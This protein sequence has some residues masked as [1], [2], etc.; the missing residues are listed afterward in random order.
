MALGA[1]GHSSIRRSRGWGAAPVRR[2]SWSSRPGT[3]ESRLRCVQSGR[4]HGDANDDIVVLLAKV[5]KRTVSAAVS[6]LATQV[7]GCLRG[8]DAR[9]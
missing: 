4:Y 6:S 5:T 9:S 7:G 8:F 3:E 2:R 1:L